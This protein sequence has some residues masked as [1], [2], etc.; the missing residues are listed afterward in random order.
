MALLV[1]E[2][3]LEAME[4]REDFYLAEIAEKLDVDGANTIG[5]DEAWE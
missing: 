1:R 2:L 4:K 5:H 3:A